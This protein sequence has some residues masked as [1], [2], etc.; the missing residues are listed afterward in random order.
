MLSDHADWQGLIRTVLESGARTVYVTHGQ[1]DVLAR[2]LRERHGID[3]KPLSNSLDLASNPV[4][5]PRSM[6]SAGIVGLRLC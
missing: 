4:D 3:A 5:G 6:R 1:S 2:F